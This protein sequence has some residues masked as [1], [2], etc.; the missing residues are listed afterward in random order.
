MRSL[1]KEA[2]IKG[3]SLVAVM[4]AVSIVMIGVISVVSVL[5]VG[6]RAIVKAKN[7]TE[8][9]ALSQHQLEII[10][11]LGQKE[12]YR[13]IS[14]PLARLSSPFEKFYT[15]TLVDY[16]R[17]DVTDI[18]GDGSTEDFVPTVSITNMKRIVLRV[19]QN[20]PVNGGAKSDV[21]LENV[22]FISGIMP[23]QID[24]IPPALAVFT[25]PSLACDEVTVTVTSDEQLGADPQVTITQQSSSAMPVDMSYSAYNG[26]SYF[27][28]G[29]YSVI[30][31]VTT[32]GTAEVY[33][34][35]IDG[36]SN[37]GYAV[38]SF[39]VDTESPYISNV[40]S[41]N[42]LSNS[43]D[44]HWEVDEGG[45]YQIVYGPV[46][47]SLTVDGNQDAGVN[48]H[49][50]IGLSSNTTYYYDVVAID[51]AGNN[52]RSEERRVGKECRSR[53]SPNH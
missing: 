45:S 37:Q 48:T 18:D 39:E 16:V 4:M 3:F 53:W 19:Y 50:L 34:S 12:F 28:E 42:V 49:S 5:P 11:R 36:N 23:I 7:R 33:V 35:G 9:S 31:G 44:I 27:Y 13:V 15:E 8:A 38:G 32:D 14:K 26:G 43:A 40:Y 10:K 17:E 21:L 30:G 41:N 1:L 22:A 47:P 20:D 24:N 2:E 46:T 51:A 29:T 6:Y 52:T 25:D